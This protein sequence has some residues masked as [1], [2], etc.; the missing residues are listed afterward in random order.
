M[1]NEPDQAAAQPAA[2]DA[3]GRAAVSEAA[4]AAAASSADAPAD[5]AGPRVST[6]G[7]VSINWASIK[8]S[9]VSSL[10][11]APDVLITFSGAHK[12]LAHK[13]T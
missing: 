5:L 1:Q 10:A 11:L 2:E 3:V 7:G 4:T 6:S 8:V 13:D 9:L 12:L